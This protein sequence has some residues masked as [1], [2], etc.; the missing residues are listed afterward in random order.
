MG[1]TQA[2]ST[3]RGEPGALAVRGFS[4]GAWQTNCYV[5]HR[6]GG[7]SCWIVD[8]GYEPGPLIEYVRRT[9][10]TPAQVV[11]TH[12]HLDHI[13]GL[14]ELRELWPAVPIRVHPAETDFLTE[15]EL[16]L[17]AMIADPLIAPAATGTVNHG[18][19]LELDGLRFEVRHTPGHSP[20]GVTLVQHENHVAIAGDVLFAGSIGRYDFPTSRFDDLMRSIREQLMTLPDA[21]RVLPGHGPATT[22]GTERAHNPYCNQRR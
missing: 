8:A 10:L 7:T 19:V 18:D 12:A 9:K 4:L 1:D 16:N 20:G 14:A 11:L 5:V 17:S 6:Q 15:P 22:I 2:T 3:A 21:T 13:A